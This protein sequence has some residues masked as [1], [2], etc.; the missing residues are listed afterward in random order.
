MNPSTLPSLRKERLFLYIG[1]ALVLLAMVMGATLAMLQLRQGVT[2]QVHTSAR[3]LAT[4]V[5]QTFD[6]LIDSIDVALLASTDEIARQ[7]AGKQPDIAAI[8]RYLETQAKRL[9]H[10]AF[11]RGT[12]ASGAVLYGPGIPTGGTTTMAD[13]EFFQRL[14]DDP[15][16]GLFMAK[17][18]IAKISGKAVLTFARRIHGKDGRFAGT[19]YCSIFVDELEAMMNQ[20]HMDD[21]GSIALRDRDLGLIVRQTHGISNPIPM[22]STQISTPFSE[23]LQRDKLAG[24]YVSDATSLDPLPRVYSYL[25]SPKYDYLVNVGIPLEPQLQSWKQQVWMVVVLLM[26]FALALVALARQIISSHLHLEGL[27]HSLASAE[28]QQRELLE[29]L[30]TGVVV[31]APATHILFTNAAA[32][33]LLGLSQDQMMGKTAV[34]PAWCFVDEDNQ[35]LTPDQYPVSRVLSALRPVD[36]IILG[37]KVPGRSRLVWVQGSAFPEFDA[38]GQ[39][40]Q[41]VVNFVD[42]TQRREADERW[43]F[44]LEGSGDGVWDANLETHEVVFSRRYQEMLGYDVGELPSTSQ[45]WE[46]RIHP[47]DRDRV[48]DEMA[49][50]MHDKGAFSTE[51]RLRCKDG[52]YKWILG[53]GMVT[54]RGADGHALRVVGMHTDISAMKA[55]ELQIWKQANFDALT[56]LPNRRLFYDR[57]DIEIRQ[58]RRNG[59][60]LALLFIDLDHF[61][62]VNDTLGHHMGDRLLVEAAQRIKQSMRDYDT[63]A[64]L[65]GDEFTVILSDQHQSLDIGAV[66]QKIIEQLSRPFVTGDNESFVSASVGIAIFPVDAT[67][68]NELVKNADQAMYAAKAAGRKCFRFFTKAMQETAVAR[69]GL[70]TDLRHALGAHQFELYYQPI[71]DLAN[72]NIHKAEGLI[73]WH[74]PLRGMVPPAEFIPVAEDIGAIH[75]IGDWVFGQAAQQVALWQD[76][77]DRDF[78]ISI[79]KSPVEFSADAHLRGHGHAGWIAKLKALGIAGHSIVIEI[80]EGVLMDTNAQVAQ[81]LLL[82]RDAGIQVAIDDFGTGYSSLAYLTKFDIDYLKIDQSFTRKLAPDA[83]DLALCEAIIVMAHKLGLKVIAEGVETEAQCTLLKQAG[84]DYGQG[85]LFSRPLTASAFEAFVQSR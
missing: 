2:A 75:S 12:D 18:L 80:T 33:K 19:V 52:S 79:N 78:Q 62:E 58:T 83:P 46:E 3:N 44:A 7:N 65:G 27:V 9:P 71:V 30:H 60:Q 49:Q 74:H 34:D 69:M 59:S 26:L 67:D 63:V 38:Q 6:G 73:R 55:A 24:D 42:M 8:S 48:H 22:G 40:K 11:L 66:A 13:R 5:S 29:N 23:A 68:V 61:K 64:R 37:V 54:T 45:S 21:G 43:R 32:C 51:Y 56:G 35:P 41:I 53:R 14:R 72:G 28:Q 84:C 57:L 31:H 81:T 4:S 20:I 1:A 17:P 70:A 15:S 50:Q 76:R 77:F 47:D 25:R 85:Y 82:F 39:L 10:V 36:S 16:T